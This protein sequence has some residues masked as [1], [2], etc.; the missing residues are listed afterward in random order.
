[1][2]N[3]LTGPSQPSGIAGRLLRR[4][5]GGSFIK[6]QMD[7]VEH[8]ALGELKQRLDRLE[9]TPSVSVLAVAV[10]NPHRERGDDAPGML[11]RHLQQQSGEQNREQAV[12]A[13]YS[14]LLRNMVPDE[15]RILAALSDG[16][17]YPM[18]HLQ[19]TS[20]LGLAATPVIEYVSTV[21]RAAGVLAVELTPLYVRQL[22]AWGL[23]ESEPEDMAQR[24]AYE[25]LETDD[26][27]RRAVNRIE[28]RGERSR[29]IRRCLRISDYGL[30]LWN[31]CQ[32]DD[33]P[34]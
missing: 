1:M 34:A 30:A 28:S 11:L 22:A 3:K 9:Q 14:A 25:I 29:V 15:V 2:D 6:E 19:A 24:V 12:D 33:G 26:N 8:L 21:G 7:R 4:L 18:I 23:T 13:Y 16:S 17:S 32:L 31:R 10:S 27:V 5:P 20:G